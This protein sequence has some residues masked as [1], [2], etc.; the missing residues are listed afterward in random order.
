M[1]QYNLS[2]NGNASTIFIA[3][4]NIH[5]SLLARG[6]CTLH[7]RDQSGA[8]QMSMFTCFWKLLS[9]GYLRNWHLEVKK[10]GGWFQLPESP[11]YISPSV[12]IQALGGYRGSCWEGEHQIEYLCFNHKGGD[13]RETVTKLFAY[14]TQLG[15][16]DNL[17]E[18]Q[19]GQVPCEK[20]TTDCTEW[21]WSDCQQVAW[22]ERFRSIILPALQSMWDLCCKKQGLLRITEIC[23]ELIMWRLSSSWL[24]PDRR[25]CTGTILWVK[26]ANSLPSSALD[27]RAC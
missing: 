18:W 9:M 10:M 25:I 24:L 20:K 26:L 12:P 6:V 13:N 5:F 16:R 2:C 23:D 15:G 4:K 14:W 1:W 17:W 22:Q 21:G 27:L 8:T 11:Q 3:K 19:T 7:T